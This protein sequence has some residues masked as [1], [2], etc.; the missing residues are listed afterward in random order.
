M[1]HT[2]KSG[3]TF[4]S[5]AKQYGV[6][7]ADLSK[8]NPQIKNVSRIFPGQVINL[9][10]NA[11]RAASHAVASNLS[12]KFDQADLL[13]KFD[14]NELLKKSEILPTTAAA[15]TSVAFGKKVSAEFKQKVID[16]AAKIGASA[17]C[18]SLRVS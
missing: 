4:T 8:A 11:Q 9:P 12:N 3:D 7:L 1:P 10:A 2:V 14:Q 13:R 17:I 6:T 18:R 15:G 16:I 5:I